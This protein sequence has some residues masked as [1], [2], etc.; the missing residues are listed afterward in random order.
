MMQCASRKSSSLWRRPLVMQKRPAMTSSQPP[1][2]RKEQ[3]KA[4]FLALL[5]D[6]EFTRIFHAISK[7]GK[8][9]KPPEPYFRT[10]ARGNQRFSSSNPRVT[11][12]RCG[13]PGHKST[14]CWKRS[15]TARYFP[16][17]GSGQNQPRPATQ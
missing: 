15:P 8:S 12:Y 1:S 11:F 13:T 2:G 10:Q 6:K 7:V 14:Q 3:F 5:A 16:S 17:S 4:Y 9:F